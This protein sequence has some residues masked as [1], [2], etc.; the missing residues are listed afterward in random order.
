MVLYIDFMNKLKQY[1]FEI[2]D[3]VRFSPETI[4]LAYIRIIIS[5]NRI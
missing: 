1:C 2:I 5:K 3:V 4:Y